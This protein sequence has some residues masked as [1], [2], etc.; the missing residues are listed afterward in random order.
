MTVSPGTPDSTLPA[1]FV[2]RTT[3]PEQA[4]AFIRSHYV[5][6]TVRFRQTRDAFRFRHTHRSTGRFSIATALHTVSV[7][8]ANEPSGQLVIG[9]VLGGRF[10]RDTENQTVRAGPRD[11]F[12][13]ARPGKPFTVRWD[14]VRM[15]IV[16]IDCATLDEVLGETPAGAATRL[17]SLEPVCPAGAR[18]WLSTVGYLADSVLPNPEVARSPLAIANA[19]RILAATALTVFPNNSIDQCSWK[20][21]TD[22]SP[23]VLRRAIEFIDSHVGDNITLSDI[24][25]AARATGRAV[26][27]A[28]RRHLGT[29]P[30]GYLRDARLEHAHRDLDSGNPANGDTVTAIA[31]RWGF[32]HPGRFATT[33]RRAYGRSPHNTLYG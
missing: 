25:F 5:D 27:R 10:E 2:F 3:D 15:Q 4:H 7:E 26:Q 31:A 11:V 1:Q 22:A 16:Q 24:A 8:C 20:D 19:A 13:M 30:T 12:V 33:Y 9:R 6:N 32:P 28:F 14:T 21:R 29:T 18:L 17:T 23:L